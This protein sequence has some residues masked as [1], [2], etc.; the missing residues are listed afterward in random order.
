MDSYRHC[1]IRMQ[2][3]KH[4]FE[5]MGDIRILTLSSA[6]KASCALCDV[7]STRLFLEALLSNAWT[8]LVKG[9]RPAPNRASLVN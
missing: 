8:I 3:L 1:G 9:E 7:A 5:H 4:A 6:M 2:N